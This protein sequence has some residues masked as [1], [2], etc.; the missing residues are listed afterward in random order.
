LYAFS[1][2][3]NAE[4]Q[5]LE[6]FSALQAEGASAFREHCQSC[7]APRLLSDDPTSAAPF[8]DWE[9]LI[10]SRN[11]PLVWARGDYAKTG[12]LP[13]VHPSGTRITSLRRLALKPRYFTNGSSPDLASVLERFREAPHGA[14]HDAPPESQLTRLTQPTRD[15]LLA[16]LQLL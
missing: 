5:R 12:I 13:Y 2:A 11:G 4:S 9:R 3:P 7:H 1:P 10:L 15:A 6:H 8:A 16:F 14:L